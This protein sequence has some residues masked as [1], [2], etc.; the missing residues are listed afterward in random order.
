MTSV[1]L[2]PRAGKS[3]AA[4]FQDVVGPQRLT[5]SLGA[6][7]TFGQSFLRTRLSGSFHRVFNSLALRAAPSKIVTPPDTKSESGGDCVLVGDIGGTNAR[8]SLWRVSPDQDYTLV[9]Q[10]WYQTADYREAGFDAVLEALTNEPEVRDNY[11]SSACFA[12]AGPVQNGVGSM[13][14][15]GWTISGPEIAE[16]FRWRVA[17]IN[18]FEALGYG[19]P[20]L[21]EE[22]VIVL[23]DVPA[24]EK[25][26]IAVLGPGTGLGEA[27]LLFDEGRKEYKVWPSEGSHSDFAPRGEKQTALMKWVVD[28][29]GYCEVEHVACGKGLERIYTF[30]AAGDK[31][32]AAD[33]T[34]MGAPE[35][36]MKALSGEDE[37]AVEALDMMLSIIG[38]EGGHM[39]LRN[40]ARG[41]VY[42]AG[43]ITPKVI[44]RVKSGV[45][46]DG[47]LH[48]QDHRFHPLLKTF[49]LCAVLNEDVGLV[50]ARY[51]A[52]QLLAAH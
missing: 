12:I 32:S 25:A 18:D 10:K 24:E 41:G 47:F 14:N 42:I 3:S 2:S 28:G 31:V 8:L 44:E 1:L 19:V 34:I 49:R 16:E 45:L 9:F 11:P 37:V 13:T 23:N 30:L 22:E 39:A 46:L 48:Q 29:L 51:F 5:T 40:L 38:A 20:I 33:D 26:P 27:Q 35:I 21:D 15:L 50:G 6:L 17:V 43:G 4:H 36:S 7:R 52:T